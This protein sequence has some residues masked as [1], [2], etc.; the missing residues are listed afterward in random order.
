MN[1]RMTNRNCRCQESSCSAFLGC[2]SPNRAPLPSFR[3]A[4]RYESFANPSRKDGVT[5]FNDR[6]IIVVKLIG[7][8]GWLETIRNNVETFA[9]LDFASRWKRELRARTTRFHWVNRVTGQLIVG[10]MARFCTLLFLP[11]RRS[12]RVRYNGRYFAWR[13]DRREMENEEKIFSIDEENKTRGKKKNIRC[14]FFSQ[15]Q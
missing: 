12:W 11:V 9:V 10:F 13:T 1:E 8:W 6:G 4:C 2:H 3:F 14:F 7:S 15:S 5:L